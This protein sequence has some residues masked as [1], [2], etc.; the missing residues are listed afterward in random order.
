MFIK[1]SNKALTSVL[2]CLFGLLFLL[3]T[4]SALAQTWSNYG[5][6]WNH[7]GAT[8][9]VNAGPGYKTIISGTYQSSTIEADVT[10]GAGGDAGF[11]FHA[12][13]LANG[14]DAYSGYYVGLSTKNNGVVL[15]RVNNNW[16]QIIAYPTTIAANTSYHLKVV[17]KGKD[18]EVFVNN[19]HII[20]AGDDTYLAGATGLRA[21]NVAATFANVTVTDN[22]TIAVPKFNFSAVKGAV[23]EPTNTVNYIEWWQ[24]FDPLIVDRE[25]AYAQTYG[26]N[27]IAIYLHYL[28]W[29]NDAAA[30]K[31]KFE[32]VLQL[33]DKHG[34][35]VSPI[36]YD[37]CWDKNPHLGAQGAPIPG[38]HNS[39]W[40]QSPGT[41]IKLTYFDNYKPKLRN[42]VQD[43][44]NAHLADD[45]I[46]F[47]EQMNEPGCGG[48]ELAM[49]IILMNDARI[50]IK[51]TGTTIPVGS[52]SAQMWEPVNFSDFYSFHPYG[53]DY[54]GPYGP[55]VLNSESMN[56]GSQSVPGIVSHYGGSATGYIMWEFGI[57][58]D[59]TRFPWGS[60]EN[61]PEPATPFHGIVY[62]DG[63]PWSL[64]DVVALNGPTANMPVFGV[65]YYNGNFATLVKNSVTPMIDFDLNTER[66]TASP[67]ASAGVSETNYAVRWSGVIR[68]TASATYTLYADS[69]NVAR[70]WVNNVLVVNKT[71]A[72]R[73]TVQGTIAL[74]GTQDYPVKVE[75]VHT[76]GP[77]N[78][79]VTWSAPTMA[80]RPLTV[81]PVAF[82]GGSKRFLSSNIANHFIRHRDSAA[83]IDSD[84]VPL[85]DSVWRMVPGLADPL[86]VSFEST[87]YPG[88]YLR[89]RDGG[90]YK[91]ASDGSALFAA[92]ATWRVRAGL[93]DPAQM[94]FE[95]FNFPGEFIRH[96]NFL[97][98]REAITPASS[99]L[100]KSDATFIVN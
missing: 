23:Y 48:T 95:S 6:T 8:H 76:T 88:Q 16:S 56:R 73:S 15:G 93:A 58:R 97:L 25:L 86:A 18:I 54:P 34:I 20:S 77:S 69:D 66:G 32:T 13:N 5:G 64:G 3:T 9:S 57:G 40:V 75:Y 67:D 94:S 28:V 100:D 96:R 14:I 49:N 60:P 84:V 63:H 78:M 4:N 17:L 21:L 89:H 82:Q 26:I 29:E 10:L 52:P 39:R 81:I 44:V 33:A 31:T 65:S 38:I 72:G 59:N 42:Y 87:N 62:P 35:K 92:D 46:L 83:R 36:F 85:A 70:V 91:D 45:R 98:Y 53:G 37:D 27:T 30:L 43:V 74:N 41:P 47:W 55:N 11:I 71:G 12:S 80:R 7:F 99:A 90:V 51:D 22:G 68:P 19:Q 79:H 24:N 2:R 61:A 50:A 1:S